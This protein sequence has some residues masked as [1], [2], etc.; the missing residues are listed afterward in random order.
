MRCVNSHRDWSVN[1]DSDFQSRLIAWSDV[2]ITSD[3]SC[4]W[5]VLYVAVAVLNRRK[6]KCSSF[7]ISYKKEY[8][9]AENFGSIMFSSNTVLKI[10]KK[11]AFQIL[12]DKI[13][14]LPKDAK[15]AKKEFT[16]LKHSK[17]RDIKNWPFFVIRWMHISHFKEVF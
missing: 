15:Q 9:L 12:R 13:P 17:K 10:I 1:R 8:R 7:L 14:E 2:Y 4:Q 3:L 6:Q 11:T 16:K 5:I